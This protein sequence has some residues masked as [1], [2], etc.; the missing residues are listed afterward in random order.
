MKGLSKFLT[1]EKVIEEVDSPVN[2]KLTVM[3]DYV[4]GKHIKGGGLTQSGGVAESVWKNSLKATKKIR[5]VARKCLILG[6][7]G[8]SIAK[9]VRKNWGEKVKITGVDID[10]VFVQ[11]GEKHLGLSD[12]NVDVVIDDAWEFVKANKDRKYDLICI[13]TYVGDQFPE[14]LGDE[15]FLMRVKNILSPGGTAVFNRLYYGEKRAEAV[16]FQKI[17]EKVFFKV[18]VIYPEA[19]IMFVCRV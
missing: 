18:E 3:R 13:D 9:L 6:L 4:W 17:L 2:G 12:Y 5:P 15:S 8:G 7:G 14:K 1:G 16:K 11:L 10:P 19:N